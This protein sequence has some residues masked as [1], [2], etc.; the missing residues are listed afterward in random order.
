VWYTYLLTDE[1]RYVMSNALTPAVIVMRHFQDIST[2]PAPPPYCYKMP[3]ASLIQVPWRRLDQ[4]GIGASL[5]YATALQGFLQTFNLCPVSR[6][7]VQDP[8]SPDQTQ[9]PFDSIY[10][11][12][13]TLNLQD[14][15]LLLDGPALRSTP[16][17]QLLPDAS[18]STLICWD[19]Q[20][21]WGENAF[22]PSL[23]LGQMRRGD[24]PSLTP[25][26]LKAPN[27]GNDGI[28]VFTNY[29]SDD[30]F[31]LVIRPTYTAQSDKGP[32][33]TKGAC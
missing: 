21:L 8:R 26:P 22:D 12:L 13:F 6:V 27:P 10:P 29:G 23:F 19:K 11:F 18:H 14:I 24:K 7:I 1:R 3:N 30:K 31:D 4:N 5:N 15:R 25:P 20:T 32:Q 9:N 28:Y 17:K 33:P 16:R 2:T